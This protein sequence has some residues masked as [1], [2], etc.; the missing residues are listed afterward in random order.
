MLSCLDV[1][2]ALH[3]NAADVAAAGYEHTGQA[4]IDLATRSLGLEDLY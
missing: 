4:L 1:P 3:R 2:E